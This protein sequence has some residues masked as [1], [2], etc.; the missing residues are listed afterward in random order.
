MGEFETIENAGTVVAESELVSDD[1][2]NNILQ[3]KGS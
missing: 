1:W 3:I 2:V